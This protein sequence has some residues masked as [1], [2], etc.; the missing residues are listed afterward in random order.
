[1]PD[2]TT[3]IFYVVGLACVGGFAYWLYET[4]KGRVKEVIRS[5]PGPAILG[6][7]IIIAT[8]IYVV[9]TRY[10]YS[11]YQGRV[12]IFDR[13]TGHSKTREY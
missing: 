10:S 8:L 1:M 11:H 4:F 5:N 12:F 2:I 3:L 7:S 9:G 13:I 6:A